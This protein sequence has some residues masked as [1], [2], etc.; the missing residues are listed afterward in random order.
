MVVWVFVWISVARRERIWE[1]EGFKVQ[2]R[3]TMNQRLDRHRLCTAAVGLVFG[4]FLPSLPSSAKAVVR[5]GLGLMIV[6]GKS[7]DRKQT[8]LILNRTCLYASLRCWPAASN[9]KP[10][11]ARTTRRHA[12]PQCSYV[13]SLGVH[14]TRFN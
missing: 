2:T 12:V 4:R 9:L 10:L 13:P 8:D 7:I 6:S 5:S 3:K 14:C 1:V 11:Q